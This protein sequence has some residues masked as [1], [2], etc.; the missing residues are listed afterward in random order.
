MKLF[1][2][3]LCIVITT[4]SCT[5]VC[6]DF[7]ISLEPTWQDLETNPNNI[8]KFG[9]KWILAGS[10]TF[11]KRAK[12]SVN[13]EK[14]YLKW[15]GPELENTIASL[16][17]GRPDKNFLPIEDNVIADGIWNKAKQRLLFDFLEDETLGAITIFYL[18]LTVP[19]SCEQ[20][21]QQGHF[22]L[23]KTCLPGPYQQCI[24]NNKLA[25]STT[26]SQPHS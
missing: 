21:F 18:V 11:K 5:L 13:L 20:L 24:Y 3:A 19:P 12:D 10:I 17:R 9:G 16:Y 22:S 7:A 4:L 14:M 8:Q 26:V 1:L 25:F 15:N 6:N 23:E 2:H